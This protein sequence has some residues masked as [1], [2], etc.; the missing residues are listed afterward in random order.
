MRS[1][2]VFVR[3]RRDRGLRRRRLCVGLRIAHDE[4][5][6]GYRTDWYVENQLNAARLAV[7]QTIR[8][9]RDNMSNVMA[10]AQMHVHG[11]PR[12]ELQITA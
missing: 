2:A 11:R 3:V 7:R 8:L 5:V 9:Q 6:A 10:C 12:F 4:S 1:S